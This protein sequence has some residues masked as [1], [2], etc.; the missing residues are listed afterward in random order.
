MI[1][2]R[3]IDLFLA[4]GTGWADAAQVFSRCGRLRESPAPLVLVP[5]DVPLP[6]PFPDAVTMLTLATLLQVDDDRLQL[7]QMHLAEAVRR[8]GRDRQQSLIPIPTPPGTT[9]AQVLLEFAN[10]EYLQVT[11]GRERHVR[12]FAEMGFA[13]LRKPVPTPSELW[14]HL[15]TLAEFGGRI[16]WDTSRAVAEKDR[17]RVRKWMSALRQKLRAAFPDISGDPFEPYAKVHAYQVK[18]ILLVSS[19]SWRL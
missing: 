9:W 13:D 4:R 18:C 12:S 3:D 10:D 6:P 11:I 2:Q 8:M 16:G 15:R 1:A 19:V 5:A 14:G 17:H 7:R